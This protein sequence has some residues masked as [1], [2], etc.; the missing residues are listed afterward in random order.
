M[1]LCN[2][3]YQSRI[4]HK[5]KMNNNKQTQ[6]LQQIHQ[7]V[8][9][10]QALENDL[11][12]TFEA[13]ESQH[14]SEIRALRK[15]IN[16]L[17]GIEEDELTENAFFGATSLKPNPLSAQNNINNHAHSPRAYNNNNN[18]ATRNQSQ[19]VA[20]N[21]HQ[22]APINPSLSQSPSN[23][24]YHHAKQATNPLHGHQYS[25]TPQPQQQHSNPNA[26]HS[27][28]YT[29][30]AFTIRIFASRTFAKYTEN[31]SS[32]NVPPPPINGNQQQ[33]SQMGLNNQYSN[34]QNQK[35]LPPN[36]NNGNG[37]QQQQQHPIANIMHKFTNSNDKNDSDHLT[38][39]GLDNGISERD[40]YKK[41]WIEAGKIGEGAF[42]RVRKITRKSDKAVFA[43]KMI[44][45]KG[46]S[47]EDIA[48]L[49]REILVLQKCDHENVVKLGDWCDTKKRI[50]MV[51]EFCD[52]GDVFERVVEYKKFSEKSAIHVIKQVAS[53]ILH[54]HNLGYVHRLSLSLFLFASCDA[55]KLS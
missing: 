32:G 54:V 27:N 45:K 55:M 50:Y 1:Q 13:I 24:Q 34:Y 8:L 31:R 22:P 44:K 4:Y 33:Q 26:Y 21:A 29:H 14:N 11:K 10:F 41:Y 35:Q 38:L 52:G 20:F 23:N 2:N 25:Y 6:K 43:L 30:T 12:D 5:H 36:P 7:L 42:A 48:A 39:S 3:L 17:K 53:G 49:Q 16:H 9:Q 40:F 46:K 37:Q 28:S 18:N 51:V 19:S 47:M 15:E